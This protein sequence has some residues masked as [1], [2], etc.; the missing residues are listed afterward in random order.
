MKRIVPILFGIQGLELSQ[1][2][3]AFF[4][5]YV[6]LGF[7]LFRRNLHSVAQVRS[8]VQQLK[9]V[10]AYPV[11]CIDEEGGKV[12]RLESLGASYRLPEVS[13][14]AHHA[15]GKESIAEHYHHIGAWLQELGITVNCAPVLDV[16]TSKTADFLRSRCIDEDPERVGVWGKT[17]IQT[18]LHHQIVPVM[19]HMPGHGV[20]EVD[21][22]HALPHI[23]SD[24]N[25]APHLA[26]FQ[27]NADCPWA[28]SSHLYLTAYEA[29]VTYSPEIVETLLRNHTG[30]SGFLV[31]DDLTMNALASHTLME[32]CT[33]ALEAGHDG[34]FICKGGPEEW[35]A[36]V[37]YCPA[38]TESGRTRLEK[39]LSVFC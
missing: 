17:V 12:T 21:S 31:S 25:L 22:H 30:F 5:T 13:S 32:R 35:H 37:E 38:F 20:G 36:V 8:L 19:K 16:R 23:A 18:L 27:V 29:C 2:E 11:I 15:H 26:P 3:S 24:V 10:A 1:E 33:L 28:M 9:Q 34:V 4:K 39:S 14:Y 7:I 6:P